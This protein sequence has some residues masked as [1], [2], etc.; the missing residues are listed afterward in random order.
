MLS[1]MLRI[2]QF[3]NGIARQDPIAGSKNC[4]KGTLE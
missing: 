3:I 1:N 2:T 4:P